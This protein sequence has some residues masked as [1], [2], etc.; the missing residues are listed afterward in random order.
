MQLNFFV[1]FNIL[2]IIFNIANYS[3]VVENQNAPSVSS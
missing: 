3:F 1:I 2:Q